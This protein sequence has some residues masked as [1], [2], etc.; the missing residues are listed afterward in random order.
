MNNKNNDAP[1]FVREELMNN[2]EGKVGLRE[3]MLLRI[4]GAFDAAAKAWPED[5]TG[6]EIT[7][8]A[9]KG[10]ELVFNG[11]RCVWDRSLLEEEIDLLLAT[12]EDMEGF[13]GEIE[14]EFNEI[15]SV[16]QK[17]LD[18]DLTQN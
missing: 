16:K 2:A 17:G 1:D 3:S 9:M 4:N 6:V 14:I 5:E 7:L 15:A 13:D 12:L 10:D 8:S 11:A 18:L